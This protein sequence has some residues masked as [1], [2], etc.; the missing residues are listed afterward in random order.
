MTAPDLAQRLADVPKGVWTRCPRCGA[1][2][3][4]TK[5]E[6]T[7][8]VCPECSRHLRL[9]LEARIE[10]L[11]DAGSF[12]EADAGLASADPLGFTD[13][14]AYPD[15]VAAMRKRTGRE[16]AAVWG[17]ATAGGLPVVLCVL[18]FG[19]MGGSM[20]SVVGEKV[21]RAAEA[22]RER[23]VPLIT[24]SASGGA[25]MQEGIF[26][27]LQ[28]AKT[29]AALRALSDAG[30]PHF[31]V[32]TDPVYGGV[33]ASFATLADV[34]VAEAD[35]SAGF[36]GPQ[37]IKQTIRQDLPAG[38]QT[39]DFLLA[40]GAVDMVVTRTELHPLLGR[41]VAFAAAVGTPLV[42]GPVPAAVPG[43]ERDGWD[44]VRLARDPGRP[45]AREYAAGLFDSFDELHGDRIADDDPAILGGL[46]RLDGAP[47]V[48]VASA[49]GRGT[50]DV[51]AHNFG[52]AHPSGYRKASRL[53]ALAE[54]LGVPV[55][56]LVDTAGAYPG[57]KAEQDNQ[58]GAISANLLQL[59]GLKVPVV[60]VVVGEGGSGGALALAGFDRL[61]MLAN[62]TFSVISPEGCATILFGDATQAPR[63]AR[64]LR[65]TAAD[66]LE[67]GIADEVLPEPGGGAHTDPAATIATVR[68]ALRRHLAA[69]AGEPIDTVVTERNRRLRAYGRLAEEVQA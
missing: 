67:M 36:A 68:A 6:R 54:R 45:L 20:G 11:V 53:F 22:A 59:A 41:L 69:L 31:S 17:T 25:R 16:D 48:V 38:F 29:A 37:V 35:T 23:R 14:K 60:T 7:R 44:V 10:V 1:S 15:R 27:L 32:L 62:A 52:M 63:A 65:L 61:L 8:G 18:D 66:L 39:A 21:T 51:V 46:A 24:C 9:P 26:S 43:E 64:A 56:T 57:L 42:A 19:F 47:V 33:T 49:K 34:I 5:L 4:K 12:T 58:S 28:M 13:S 3:Y 2:L 50:A 30:V 55:V 40:H